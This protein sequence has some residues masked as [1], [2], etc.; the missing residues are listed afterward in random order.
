MRCDRERTA[1]GPRVH[2]RL[3]QPARV[4]STNSIESQDPLHREYNR[5]RMM[6]SIT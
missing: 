4:R 5:L 1:A 2:E 6:I 3:L